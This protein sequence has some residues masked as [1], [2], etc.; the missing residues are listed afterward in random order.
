LVHFHRAG[1]GAHA[2]AVGLFIA[3]VFGFNLLIGFLLKRFTFRL[4]LRDISKRVIFN[5]NVIRR[6]LS[7]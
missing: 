6:A 5:N 2:T 1:L 7:Q 4:R 3:I